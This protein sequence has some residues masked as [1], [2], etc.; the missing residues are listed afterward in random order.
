MTLTFASDRRGLCETG[1]RYMNLLK[2]GLAAC[3]AT[4]SMET[5]DYSGLAQAEACAG[6]VGRSVEA[7]TSLKADKG[8]VRHALL[9]LLSI[10][11]VCLSINLNACYHGVVHV[12]GSDG[13][14]PL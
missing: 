3:G 6:D 10:L 2:G 1:I 11:L 12:V 9:C 5:E 14:S 8:A 7:W 13:M 4:V